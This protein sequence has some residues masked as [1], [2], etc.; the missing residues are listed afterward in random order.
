M[1]YTDLIVAH[2]QLC[3]NAIPSHSDM[4]TLLHAS[5]FCHLQIFLKINFKK[6]LQAFHQCRTFWIQIRPNVLI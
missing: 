4:L 3:L 5:N 2:V 6:I 1:A